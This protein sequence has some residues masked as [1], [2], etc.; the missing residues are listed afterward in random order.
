MKT[1]ALLAMARSASIGTLAT[2]TGLAQE[3]KVPAEHKKHVENMVKRLSQSAAHLDKSG[4]AGD[5]VKTEVQPE[6]ARCAAERRAGLRSRSA[7]TPTLPKPRPLP[8]TSAV[9]ESL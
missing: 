6:E 7:Q 1:K 4:D 5:Q 2:Q 3:H 9:D 8:V